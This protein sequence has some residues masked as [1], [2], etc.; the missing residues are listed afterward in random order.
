MPAAHVMF[1]DKVVHGIFLLCGTFTC[2]QYIPIIFHDFL[3][4]IEC[5]CIKADHTLYVHGLPMPTKP[6]HL[7]KV[8]CHDLMTD[9]STIIMAEVNQA[10][11]KSGMLHS[12]G[13]IVLATVAN[14]D[15]ALA[16]LETL[17]GSVWQTVGPLVW[18]TSNYKVHA[19]FACYL[20]GHIVAC[21]PNP[22]HSAS[23]LLPHCI[24]QTVLSTHN[25]TDN[26]PGSGHIVLSAMAHPS[27]AG[28]PVLSGSGSGSAQA[29]AAGPQHTLPAPTTT[30]KGG[31]TVHIHHLCYGALMPFVLQVWAHNGR[32]IIAPP[33]LS[34]AFVD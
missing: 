21:C 5:H 25:M 23:I 8:A 13:Y 18:L 2:D 15:G 24:P 31:P 9:P 10:C 27:G 30:L 17:Q 33:W 34:V 32:N 29:A 14:C 20:L 7:L 11:N 22:R 1:S 26:P 6:L 19:C 4:A 16:C 12:D 3:A 28:A